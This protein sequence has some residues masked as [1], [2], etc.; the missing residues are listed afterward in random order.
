MD[1]LL[2]KEYL[3]Y[4]QERKIISDQTIS[5]D[6]DKFISGENKKLLIAGLSGVEKLH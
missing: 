6:L 3:N 4:I 1:N 5:I 2:V